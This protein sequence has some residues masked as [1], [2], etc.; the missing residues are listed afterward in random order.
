LIDVASDDDARGAR[1]LAF[2]TRVLRAVGISAPTEVEATMKKIVLALAVLT[3]CVS[4]KEYMSTMNSMMSTMGGGIEVKNA[5]SVP[6]CKVS[7]FAP[8]DEANAKDNESPDVVLMQPG[9]EKNLT[10]PMSKSDAGS[11]APPSKLSMRVYGCNI[12][13]ISVQT[14]ELITTMNDVDPQQTLVTIH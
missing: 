1:V 12:E 3:T 11:V 14:G 7:V 4:C 5:L 2:G 13:G 8:E 9:E 6:V 10:Y